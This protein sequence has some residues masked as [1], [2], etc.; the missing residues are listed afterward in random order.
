MLAGKEQNCTLPIFQN[1][2]CEKLKEEDR[3]LFITCLSR[4]RFM[5][6]N[7]GVVNQHLNQ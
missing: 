5:I 3:G 1:N 7:T 6:I 2:S 4:H